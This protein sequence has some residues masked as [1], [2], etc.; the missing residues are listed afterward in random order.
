MRRMVARCG[1]GG[2]ENSAISRSELSDLNGNQ[3]IKRT[4]GQN[5]DLDKAIDRKDLS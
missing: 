5:E 2:H 4:G 1:E 3:S